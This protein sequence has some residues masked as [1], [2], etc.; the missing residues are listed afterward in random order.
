MKR[1][2]LAHRIRCYADVLQ[3]LMLRDLKRKYSQ[4]ASYTGSRVLSFLEQAE[5]D[6]HLMSAASSFFSVKLPFSSHTSR[7]Q[8]FA[9]GA[10]RPQSVQAYDSLTCACKLT[11][12]RGSASYPSQLHGSV[13]YGSVSYGRPVNEN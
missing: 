12:S 4:D 3:P 9:T 1:A 2:F 5:S 6:L 10:V 11:T 13:S 7:T 8:S